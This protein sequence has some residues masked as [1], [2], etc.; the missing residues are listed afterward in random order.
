[1]YDYFVII[2]QVIVHVPFRVVV[3]E[4]GKL[5]AGRATNFGG[6]ADLGSADGGLQGGDESGRRES[7]RAAGPSPRFA[8]GWVFERINEIELGLLAD[9]D[10]PLTGDSMIT[11]SAN[12]CRFGIGHLIGKKGRNLR[13]IERFCGAFLT[14]N[15]YETE[16]EILMWGP[17]RACAL[18]QFVAEA[19]EHGC[20]SIVD[21]LS[22]LSF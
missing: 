20:Y 18:V 13:K 10:G 16:V 5:E 1:M 11:H 19:F 22:S 4:D 8:L 6:S 14:L 12:V 3:E 15:D 17:L 21:T 9:F 7:H 2:Y